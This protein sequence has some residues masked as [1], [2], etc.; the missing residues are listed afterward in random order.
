MAL[1]AL[2]TLYAV[3]GDVPAVVTNAR[4]AEMIKYAS[5]TLLAT[6]ISFSNEIAAL[7]S[8]LGGVDAVDVMRG[9]HLSRYLT[10][11]AGPAELS[12]FLLPGCGYGGSCLPK[13][14]AALRT[15]GESVGSPMR[16]LTAVEHTNTSAPE[17]LIRSCSDA[18][19]G[20]AGRRVALL[21][22]A[23]KAGTDDTRH[24]A[25]FPVLAG[26]LAGGADVIAHD[27]VV[28]PECLTGFPGTRWSRDLREAVAGV[29]AVVLVTAWPDYLAVPALVR[30]AD[31]P[32]VVVD[33]RRLLDPLS[34]PRY[35]GVGR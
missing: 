30:E 17:S 25:S 29:D 34:V 15:L 32:P 24:S 14:V 21:G 28:G 6:A 10:G 4:T 2:R 9:V 19:G 31:R 20:L 11:P 26:L 13:D 35:V 33:G 3:L 23:F 27:P 12:A 1:D 18:L 8:A 16:V 5:N 22:L 7:A